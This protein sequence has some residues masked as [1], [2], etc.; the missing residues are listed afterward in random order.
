MKKKQSIVGVLRNGVVVNQATREEILCATIFELFSEVP[1]L[2]GETYSATISNR[3]TKGARLFYFKP[4]SSFNDCLE[5]CLTERG[6][7]RSLYF[8]FET[9]VY[10]TLGE[11]QKKKNAITPRWISFELI[12]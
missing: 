7:Y 9:A 3:K 12:K 1:E 8:D 2:D 11:K 4:I 10:E 5:W 6:D